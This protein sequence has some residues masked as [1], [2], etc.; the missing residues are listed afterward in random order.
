MESNFEKGWN[1]KNTENTKQV[2]F[3]TVHTFE[4]EKP[5]KN[6]A[7]KI[8]GIFGNAMTIDNDEN[9]KSLIRNQSF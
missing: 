8:K 3:G 1:S 4:Y 5:E 2:T 6:L 7:K 9:L